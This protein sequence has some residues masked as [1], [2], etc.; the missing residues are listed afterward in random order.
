MVR[1]AWTPVN[2]LNISGAVNLHWGFQLSPIISYTSPL[3][4]TAS[5]LS[6]QSPEHTSRRI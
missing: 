3:P 4:Y 2:T 6:S 1:P 5:R